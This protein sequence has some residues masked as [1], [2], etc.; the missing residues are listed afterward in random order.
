MRLKR[1]IAPFIFGVTIGLL[2]GVGFFIFKINDWF[3]KLRDTANDRITV[4]EQP[5]KNVKEEPEEKKPAREK[6]KINVGKSSKVN[7]R[8]VDSLIKQDSH[9]NIATD[10]L[11]SVKSVKVIKV[12][13][14]ATVS[15]SSA[16]QPPAPEEESAATY[17]VEFWKTPLNS[18]GYRFSRTKV[19]L[20]GFPDFSNVLLYELG[21]AYYLRSADQVFKLNYTAEFRQPER[22]TDPDLLAKL[23]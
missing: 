6:F 2:A 8:E 18:R 21:D 10:Q 1:K 13:D 20:Y 19:M 3:T 23:N 14:N 11:L 9:I 5:V 15:D 17:Q 7:Y 16:E 4:I 22:V 12:A